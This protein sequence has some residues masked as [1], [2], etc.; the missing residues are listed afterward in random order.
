M[1][2]PSGRG[3]RI[4]RPAATT[5]QATS[6]RRDRRYPAWT[7]AQIAVSPRAK[8]GPKRRRRGISV[9]GPSLS[10]GMTLVAAGSRVAAYSHSLGRGEPDR[11]R[12][13]NGCRVEAPELEGSG[14][15]SPKGPLVLIWARCSVAQKPMG[16]SP[17]TRNG[18]CALECLSVIGSQDLGGL[19]PD[20]RSECGRRLARERRRS[21][22]ARNARKSRLR[23]AR[24]R[25]FPSPKCANP[26]A[27]S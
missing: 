26:R 1:L 13:L 17:E 18:R 27:G 2:T 20:D 4:T 9:T 7:T 8:P 12:V 5:G 6:E 22:A 23:P 14:F 3:F 15:L 24:H 10:F 11:Q 16:R 25:N 19:L 21:R